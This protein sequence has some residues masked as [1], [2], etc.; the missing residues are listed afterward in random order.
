MGVVTRITIFVS[1]V[2]AGLVAA[3]LASLP[4]VAVALLLTVAGLAW[5][6]YTVAFVAAHPCVGDA[7]AGLRAF[8]RRSGEGA[9]GPPI[10]DGDRLS[11]VR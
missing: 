4:E 11:A 5:A 9:G 2:L 10:A 8:G 6:L 1:L 7:V 3:L